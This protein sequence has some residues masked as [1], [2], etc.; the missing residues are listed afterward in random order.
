MAGAISKR[1]SSGKEPGLVTSASEFLTAYPSYIRIEISGPQNTFAEDEHP[2]LTWIR[3]FIAKFCKELANDYPNLHVAFWQSLFVVCESDALES[4]STQQDRGTFLVGLDESNPNRMAWREEFMEWVDSFEDEACEHPTFTDLEE[5]SQ[6]V[7]L[8]VRFVE[9]NQ[10]G[11]LVVD[12]WICP[13][14]SRASMLTFNTQE[15]SK[16]NDVVPNTAVAP[17]GD[18]KHCSFLRPGDKF[19]SGV[20]TDARFSDIPFAVVYKDG[21][22]GPQ[23]MDLEFWGAKDSTED[24]FIPRHRLMAVKRKDTLEVVWHRELRLDKFWGSGRIG[25]GS[26]R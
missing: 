2:L 24:N 6:P 25:E 5:A 13:T 10:L 4:V 12:H 26:R 23:E 11:P 21:V 8:A 22:V 3:S 20:R 9:Q 19:I 7:S 14:E 17:E 18:V 16:G 1:R 15:L